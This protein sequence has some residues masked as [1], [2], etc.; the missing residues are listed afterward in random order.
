MPF[1]ELHHYTSK[2]SL[3]L[4]LD[5]DTNINYRFSLPN[6][7]FDYIHAGV[8]VLTSPL[9]ELKN[10]VDS[11]QV[12]ETIRS[13]EPKQIAKHISAMLENTDQLKIYKANCAIAAAELNWE[14][15]KRTLIKILEKYA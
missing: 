5:K 8:P 11:Y 12:G 6:K 9:V 2:A 1:Q 4:T 14:N 10:I 13:H 15:E 7:L 3:G